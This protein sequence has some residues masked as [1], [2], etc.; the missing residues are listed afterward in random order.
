MTHS[1]S[2]RRHRSG[3][4]RRHRTRG[5]KKNLLVNGLQN[6]GSSVQNVARKSAPVLKSG[7]QNLFGLLS[8]GVKS[9]VQGVRSLSRR[10]TRTRT[11]R[12]NKH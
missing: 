6:V 1:R 9:G 4:N 5:S 2:H 3:H 12:R 8:K 7:I 10:G 11:R